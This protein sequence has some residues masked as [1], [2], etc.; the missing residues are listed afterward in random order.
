MEARGRG[1]RNGGRGWPVGT[2]LAREGSGLGLET[3]GPAAGLWEPP[4][5]SLGSLI[6]PCAPAPLAAASL[7][8]SPFFLRGRPGAEPSFHFPERVPAEPVVLPLQRTGCRSRALGPSYVTGENPC[9]GSS[10]ALKCGWTPLSGSWSLD[11]P[12]VGA[13]GPG[14]GRRCLSC[15]WEPR[16]LCF[17]LGLQL[18]PGRRRSA[19]SLFRVGVQSC[20]LFSCTFPFLTRDWFSSSPVAREHSE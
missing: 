15:C 5:P 6:T 11:S 19:L 7:K 9:P 8:S 14:G 16:K 4:C 20:R 3:P 12:G 13:W 2:W 17:P 1:A 18:G 10:V